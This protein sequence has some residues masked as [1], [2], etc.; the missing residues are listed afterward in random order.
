MLQRVE[1]VLAI[2]GY[3]VR[4]LYLG[5][6]G[7]A[8]PIAQLYNLTWY[9]SDRKKLPTVSIETLFPRIAELAIRLQRAIPRLRG[10]LT[11][12]E[13]SGVALICQWLKPQTLFEFG[14]YNGR[15]TLNLAL[16]SPADARVFTL[17]LPTPGETLLATHEHDELA[18]LLLMVS[19][20]SGPSP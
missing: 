17:D 16:N 15:T 11:V 9:A 1:Q 10:N 5:A 14:T 20:G 18:R 12:E 4:Q 8:F 7:K 13:L 3:L 19:G 2:I 6:R